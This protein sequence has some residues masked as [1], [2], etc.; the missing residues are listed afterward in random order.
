MDSPKLAGNVSHGERL[1]WMLGIGFTEQEADALLSLPELDVGRLMLF[2][3]DLLVRVSPTSYPEV[4]FSPDQAKIVKSLMIRQSLFKGE[5]PKE[6]LDAVVYFKGYLIFICLIQKTFQMM[7]KLCPTLVPWDGA[8]LQLLSKK[9]AQL[10]TVHDATESNTTNDVVSDVSI[11]NVTEPALGETAESI[12]LGKKVCERVEQMLGT[13]ILQNLRITLTK[14]ARYD[15][16]RAERFLDLLDRGYNWVEA[17]M[18]SKKLL[19]RSIKSMSDTEIETVPWDTLVP[20]AAIRCSRLL[21]AG[22]SNKEALRVCRQSVGSQFIVTRGPAR[23]TTEIPVPIR[24]APSGYPLARLTRM[25]SLAT[26]TDIHRHVMMETDFTLKLLFA[27]MFFIDGYLLVPCY[28]ELTVKWIKKH[29]SKLKPHK[30]RKIAYHEVPDMESNGLNPGDPFNHVSL[31]SSNVRAKGGSN[32]VRGNG[33]RKQRG[34]CAA[35][36]ASKSS[37]QRRGVQRNRFHPYASG[38]GPRSNDREEKYDN[39]LSSNFAWDDD[40]LAKVSRTLIPRSRNSFVDDDNVQT[41]VS[42]NYNPDRSSREKHVNSLSRNIFHGGDDDLGGVSRNNDTSSNRRS[43][44]CEVGR[45]QSNRYD[46]AYNC[47]SGGR[48]NGSEERYNNALSLKNNSVGGDDD[49]EEPR[50]HHTGSKSGEQYVN[51]WSRNNFVDDDGMQTRVS[52]NYRTGISSGEEYVN[53]LSRNS[54]VCCDEDRDGVSRNYISG[55]NRGD[56]QRNQSNQ[57]GSVYGSDRNDGLNWSDQPIRSNES[58]ERYVNTMSMKSNFV[59]GD[60]E[61]TRVS[62]S[63][64]NPRSRNIF[65][66]DDD[67]HTGV[68]RNYITGRENN[69][70]SRNSFVSSDDDQAE[71]SRNYNTGSNRRNLSSDVGRNQL[72]QYASVCGNDSGDGENWSRRY[73]QADNSFSGGRS[74]ESGGKYGKKLSVMNNFVGGDDD[75]ARVSR[76]HNTGSNSKAQYFNPRFRNS[77]VGDDDVH[78]GVSSDFNTDKSSREKHGYSLSGSIFVRGDDDQSGVSRNH[79]TGSNRQRLRGAVGKNESNQYGY[80]HDND[81]SDGGNRSGRYGL[82]YDIGSGGRRNDNGENYGSGCDA[83]QARASG[84]HNTGVSRSY[85]TG[86][87]RQNISGDDGRNQLNQYRSAY[88]HENSEG[89]NWPSRFGQAYNSGRN[90]RHNIHRNQMDNTPYR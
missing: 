41:G 60:D 17:Y 88:S 21:D 77:Y 32:N 48:N 7:A 37:R 27:T 28:N 23:N 56:V 6:H 59:G 75:Q 29:V 58:G 53:P 36:V 39:T 16:T 80:F 40:D 1:N 43:V 64:A 31:P 5:K 26:I 69:Q 65:V 10:G 25:Q 15:A 30:L 86:S 87:S 22:Y 11:F 47:G 46:Q 73:D 71:V 85:N 54:F 78:T 81:R 50:I 68:P 20:Y 57:Y 72:N 35:P 44:S 14:L 4:T 66:G 84:T 3:P 33:R 62:R 19:V 24:I 70:L 13:G 42:S 90:G 2:Q 63:Y 51:L 76:T 83:D 45:H 12:A 49:Q 18:Y 8:S 38:C 74:N 89:G 55:S 9:S 34:P 67:V 52:T 61:Q 79:T 82:D